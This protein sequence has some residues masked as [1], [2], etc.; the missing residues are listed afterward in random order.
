LWN[1]NCGQR[2]YRGRIRARC[3]WCLILSGIR[4]LGFTATFCHYKDWNDQIV[5]K[6]S[7]G[8]SAAAGPL[9]KVMCPINTYASGFQGKFGFEHASFLDFTE[10]CSDALRLI[11]KI[12][13]I[14]RTIKVIHAQFNAPKYGLFL[15]SFK[16]KFVPGGMLTGIQMFAE[17]MPFVSSIKIDYDMSAGFEN[18]PVTIDSQIIE[19][20]GRQTAQ[21]TVAFTKS[22]ETTGQWSNH[23]PEVKGYIL[24]PN[25]VM[26]PPSFVTTDAA[27][28]N[29]I[30][31]STTG[32][33]GF[34]SPVKTVI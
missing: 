6:F 23:N 22:Y 26:A 3:N 10:Y 21:K 2:W 27:G 25:I 30:Y 13:K 7:T 12:H 15:S 17:G 9:A 34:E 31:K 19:N 18:Y 1:C 24:S 4:L 14:S 29:T 8:S 5:N 32:Q 11:I 16:L 28:V 33:F 20:C